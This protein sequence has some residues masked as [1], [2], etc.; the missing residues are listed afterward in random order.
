MKKVLKVT[1]RV[2][3]VIV[4]IVVLSGVVLFANNKIQLKNEE[5]LLT[6]LGELVE[7]DGHNISVYNEGDGEKTLVFLQGGG[8]PSPILEAKSLFSLLSD[9]YRIVVL[10]RPGYGF[11]DEVDGITPLETIISWEREALS[12]LG[13][14]AP[15]ILI[16]HSA[17]GIEAILW[18][19]LYP[20]EV[21][22]IIGLDMSVPAYYEKMYDM[23]EMRA[24]KEDMEVSVDSTLLLYKTFGL[25]R[26]Q[27]IDDFLDS[28]KTG[29]LTDE[30]K[31]IYKALAYKIYPNKT[32][33][34]GMLSLP[35]DMA[36]ICSM[37]KPDVPMLLFISDGKELGMDSPE[38]WIELQKEYISDNENGT[39]IQLDCGHF[40][41]NI[42]YGRISK[43][44]K[45]YIKKLDNQE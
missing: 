25:T 33:M 1:G 11:S 21:E 41:H 18:A 10:E 7:V 17:S 35:D 36:L 20:D 42:E 34:T 13:I 38:T 2:L 12:N 31:I 44:T 40:M 39:Y 29:T 8:L 43:E 6:P 19:Q 32:M 24:M 27:P 22:A 15:Y 3:L 26:F 14:D 28:F 30:D 5:S 16:P 9:E 23:D 37:P 4:V 45:S